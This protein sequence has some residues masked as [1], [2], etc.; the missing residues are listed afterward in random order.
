MADITDYTG[1]ITSEH[2]DKPKF[3][4]MVA[5]A[6]QPVVDLQ[7][8]MATFPAA[9]D[10]DDAIGAQLD[11]V[12]EWVGR[13]R[14]LTVPIDNP[15][16]SLDYLFP[17]QLPVG[18]TL[19]RTG[20]GWFFDESGALNDVLDNLP[21]WTADPNSLTLLGLLNEAASENFVRN[22][23]MQGA[24]AGTMP[25]DWSGAGTANGI[26][27]A[28]AATGTEHGMAY[29]DLTFSGTATANGTA[30]VAFEANNAIAAVN[31][32]TWSESVFVK[33]TSGSITG[34]GLLVAFDDLDATF[35]A[36]SEFSSAD[37][38]TLVNSTVGRF[39]TTGTLANA[40]TAFVQPLLKWSYV[41]G[42]TYNFT[43]RIYQ[44][45]MEKAAAPSSPI[46]TTGAAV[47]RS[48]DALTLAVGAGTYD[49]RITRVSGVTDLPGTVVSGSTYV[50]P[51]DPEPVQS[52]SFTGDNDLSFNLLG[53]SRG[54]DQSVWWRPFDP[55][56]QLISLP[57]D[58]YRILLKGIIGANQW[59]GTVEGAY[60]VFAV[61]FEGLGFELLI[62][63]SGPLEITFV[64]AGPVIN[65]VTKALLTDGELITKPAG[66]RIAGFL[67]STLPLFGFDSNTDTVAGFDLGHWE[68]PL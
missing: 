11:V 1:L 55:A 43:L 29:V 37:I 25:T 9:Y 42:Q 45:Q 19:A 18:V 10:V 41:L 26:T 56:T 39:S 24:A 63:E 4:A 32:D 22:S 5:G 46:P 31:G 68:S 57:D 58:Q 61:I 66:V 7:N 16:F 54:L 49:V 67:T 6:L 35:A 3:A 44:P 8:L 2:A 52:V 30:A 27:V 40:S 59:D 48:A 20:E 14:D 36:L 17:T 47:S 12:G 33:L 62:E 21:R 38:T 51:N 65:V 64:I 50:V 53:D 15:F 28:V 60:A 13:T 23:T 34:S